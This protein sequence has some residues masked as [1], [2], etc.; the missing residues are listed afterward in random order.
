MRRL[1]TLTLLLGITFLCVS[2]PA[3]AGPTAGVGVHGDQLCKSSEDCCSLNPNDWMA[4]FQE[5]YAACFGGSV[6][7]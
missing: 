7:Q 1:L 5:S 6:L 4:D 3:S 2:Q